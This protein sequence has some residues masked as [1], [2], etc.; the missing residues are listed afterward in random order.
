VL[1]A[2]LVEVV[3][4]G[5]RVSA[6]R[7]AT[8]DG[9]ELTVEAREFVLALGGIENAHM[10]LVG[11]P[12]RPD[13]IG[14][15][16]D[17]VGRYFCEHPQTIIGVATT[18]ADPDLLEDVFDGRITDPAAAVDPPAVIRGVIVPTTEAASSRGLLSFG[19]HGLPGAL[20]AE[21]SDP[22]FGLTAGD[23]A[24]FA[25]VS[26]GLE[27]P[28]ALLLVVTGEQA[29]HADSRVALA[30]H[31]NHSTRPSVPDTSSEPD[32]GCGVDGYIRIS[33]R[34]LGK[35]GRRFL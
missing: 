27:M 11:S 35:V 16:N 23:V 13:G 24:M 15:E 26:Q 14:N 21:S 1:E 20:D 29:L 12:Q 6:V 4:A 8:L 19:A 31:R 10:L 33:L 25:E 17:L 22:L 32:T 18:T 2:N 9:G 7:G 28:G 30:T 5:D 3:F 34:L